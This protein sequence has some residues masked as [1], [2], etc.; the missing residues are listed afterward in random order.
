MEAWPLAVDEQRDMGSHFPHHSRESVGRRVPF[1]EKRTYEDSIQGQPHVV[2][3][4][5]VTP[6]L[7]PCTLAHREHGL[8]SVNQA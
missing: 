8:C 2:H 3:G 4:I 7:L 6:T 5:C 1:L